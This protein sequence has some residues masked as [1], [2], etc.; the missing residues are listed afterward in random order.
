MTVC[1]KKRFV[2]KIEDTSKI[3]YIIIFDDLSNELKDKEIEFLAK[4]NRHFKAKVIYSS[5]YFH[6]LS[7]GARSQ[8]DYILMYPKIPNEKIVLV[9]KELNLSNDPK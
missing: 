1:K 8:I 5:Q 3:S 7:K 2:K 4:W 9:W 6:D